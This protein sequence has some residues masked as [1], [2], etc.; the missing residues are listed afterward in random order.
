MVVLLAIQIC[1][2][3]LLCSLFHMNIERHLNSL[4]ID[5]FHVTYAYDKGLSIPLILSIHLIQVS[6]TLSFQN[7]YSLL[8]KNKVFFSHTSM[9]H[10]SISQLIWLNMFQCKIFGIACQYRY[11]VLVNIYLQECRK[12]GSFDCIMSKFGCRWLKAPPLKV[13]LLLNSNLF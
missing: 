1:Y 2:S 8:L 5:L 6:V 7:N 9:H 4:Q 10:F 13:V 12:R 11:T 3:I